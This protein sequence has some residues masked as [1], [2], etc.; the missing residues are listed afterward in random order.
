M[1]VSKITTTPTPLSV[2]D[3]I[4]EVI[5]GKLDTTAKAASATTADSATTLSG[6]TAT[7]AELNYVDGVT[8]NVQ[9]QLNGKL[10]TSGTAAKATA[11][12]SGNNIANTYATKAQAVTNL[13]ASG[14]TVTF[15]KADGSTGTFTTQ[16][17][18]Y[19]RPL[20]R[21]PWVESRQVPV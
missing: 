14:K 19:S 7:V 16:D 21:P 20:L 12:A 4:N 5:D 2:V 1:A 11:D 18:T 17:T 9:T 8:S 10:S 15:T 13:T 3:K 6:L